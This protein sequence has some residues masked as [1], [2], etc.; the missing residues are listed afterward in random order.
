MT[1]QEMVRVFHLNFGL[2]IHTMP[3]EIDARTIALRLDLIYEEAHEIQ[4]AFKY[5]DLASVAKELADLLYVV[6]GT[7]VSC[8]IDL[9]E[10]DHVPTELRHEDY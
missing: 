4:Q 2:E 5:N 7:A 6:Y 1:N 10:V 9:V 3:V 8:G